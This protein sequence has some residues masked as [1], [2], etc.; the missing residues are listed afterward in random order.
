MSEGRTRRSTVNCCFAH[1]SCHCTV[2]V[3]NHPP[4][5]PPPPCPIN[6]CSGPASKQIKCTLSGPRPWQK[7]KAKT[8]RKQDKSLGFASQRHQT[9]VPLREF[10]TDCFPGGGE[11]APMLNI[12]MGSLNCSYRGS[13]RVWRIYSLNDTAE[14]WTRAV[15]APQRQT[16][17]A[18]T[19]PLL[20]Y[21]SFNPNR[22]SWAST[23][24]PSPPLEQHEGFWPCRMELFTGMI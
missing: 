2:Y 7:V 17:L 22:R 16:S 11:G 20:W 24:P 13:L 10:F 14:G 4:L 21:V 1:F 23:Q 9:K 8:R 12:L 18:E 15:Q 5:Q 19:F 3:R 6:P